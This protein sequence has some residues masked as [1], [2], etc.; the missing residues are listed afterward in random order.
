[1]S[2]QPPTSLT[3][4]STS[5]EQQL[6]Q[7][8]LELAQ[9]KQSIQQG[10]LPKEPTPDEQLSAFMANPAE[11]VAAIAQTVVEKN[12][13]HFLVNMREEAEFKGALRAFRAAYP[14]AIPFE[15]LIF[16]EVAKI[17]H[18]DEDG[19]L[20]PWNELLEQGLQRFQIVFK[21]T[22]KN[23]PELLKNNSNDNLG[24]STPIYKTALAVMEGSGARKMPKVL[25]SFTR[26]QIAKMSPAQFSEN[27]V[28]I[29]EAMRLGRIS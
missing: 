28:A 23:S 25:P 26:D 24:T 11:Y 18:T 16:D 21:E 4:T 20:A 9:L 7:A 6:H 14:D 22:L 1:M 8:Q 10:T 27:E 13:D 12:A 17:I 15:T 3:D 2:M 29:E 5:L 19:V